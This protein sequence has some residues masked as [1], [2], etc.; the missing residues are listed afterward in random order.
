[1]N[2]V[3]F[4]EI[5]EFQK[6]HDSIFSK[7]ITRKFSRILTFFLVKYIPGISPNTISVISLVL[8]FAAAAGFFSRSY[9]ARAIGVLL[10]QIS[11]VFDCSDGEVARATG[12]QSDYG[13]FLD[14]TFDRLKEVVVIG[15]ITHHLARYT[16][17][18]GHWTPIWLLILGASALIGLL[19][20]AYIREAKKAAFPGSRKSEIYI[21]KTMY[22]GTVDIFIFS[23][24]VAILF[25]LEFWLLW[26]IA[27]GSIPLIIKQILSARKQAMQEALA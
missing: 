21:S 17:L 22:L 27:I 7:L 14:S 2:S 10:L 24:S 12:R 16:T 11:F 13:A 1:M 20:I 6:P 25:Q 15:A 5:K 4:K 8:A 19:L 18:I 23:V 9:V 3:T 26:A